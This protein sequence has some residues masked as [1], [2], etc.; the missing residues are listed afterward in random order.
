M[1]TAV[2]EKPVPK[3]AGSGPKAPVT[4]LGGEELEQ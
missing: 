1:G 3:P 4:P 2:G